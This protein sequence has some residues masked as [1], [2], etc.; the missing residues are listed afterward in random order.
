[1]QSKTQPNPPLLQV[2]NLCLSVQQETGLKPLV[3]GV[4]FTLEKG[5][6]LGLVGESGS[7]KSL[8]ALS[9]PRLLSKALVQTA[10]EI[11]FQG[12][13][14][15]TLSEKEL[16][17]LRGRKI[18]FIF[19]EPLTALNPL[20]TIEKQIAE[21]FY[22]HKSYLEASEGILTQKIIAEKVLELLD[23]VGILN[24][25]SRLNAYPHELSGGQRQ[26]IVIAMAIALKPDLLIADEPTTALDVTIQAQV[27]SLIQQLQEK[28]GMGLLLINHD[29]GVI[30]HMA[31]HTCVMQKGRVIEDGKTSDLFSHPQHPYTRGLLEAEPCGSP[32]PI[33]PHAPILLEGQDV[34]VWFP[35]KK[36]FFGRTVSHI[37]AV[38]GI[39]FTLKSG[40]T[41]GIV[42]ESGSG[43]STLG[44]AVIRLLPAKGKIVFLGKSLLDLSRKEMRPL[45]ANLQ[46]V[47]QDP[48]GALSPR[49]TAGQ[50]V[51]E[52]LDIHEPSLTQSQKQQRIHDVFKAVGL[53]LDM[54]DRYPHEFSGGQRQRLSIARA[55]ILKPQVIVLDEPTSA[56]DRSVQ[57]QIIDLLRTLQKDYGLSYLFISHDLKV[58]RAMSHRVMVMKSGQVVEINDANT[59]FDHPQHPYTQNLVQASLAY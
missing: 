48:F 46:I 40:E 8:T 3:E 35:V 2:K 16:C 15:H 32:C 20:H 18:G 7:G 42:G 25:K 45:R 1:M 33:S 27:L 34:R 30:R 52:G 23:E 36:G 44:Y 50:I 4:H 49:M 14:L 39:N 54:E 5:Q 41:L 31:Q 38:D 47:F 29:L 37:K 10:G 58:V 26:R 51:G 13:P 59:L 43:K 22:T 11:F 53:L 28:Y 56:L 17:V 24:P 6:T 19:Q 57:V 12:Q 21:V 55:L 9:I